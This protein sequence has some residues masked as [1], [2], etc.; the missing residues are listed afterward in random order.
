MA[1]SSLLARPSFWWLAP[2]S[3]FG[4]RLARPSSYVAISLRGHFLGGRLPSPYVAI[5]LRDR[6]LVQFCLFARPS[7][8]V[9]VSLHG[10]LLSPCLVISHL[11]A[12][13]SPWC[14]APVSVPGRPPSP[15]PFVLRLQR[16]CCINHM[17]I[18]FL[19]SDVL[20]DVS[21]NESSFLCEHLMQC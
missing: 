16:K 17:P 14:L 18:I 19:S 8:Y 13:P 12:R 11:L 15:W 2:I 7:S 9:A 3:S 1:F 10:L 4:R 5:I 21:C 6:H 20:Q